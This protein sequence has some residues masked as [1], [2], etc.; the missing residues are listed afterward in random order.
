MVLDT[1]A[2][3]IIIDEEGPGCEWEYYVTSNGEHC[4]KDFTKAIIDT[5][6]TG[7]GVDDRPE[8]E[9]IGHLCDDHIDRAFAGL[10]D[11]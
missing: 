7:I 5:N 11:D 6:Y 8:G 10:N 1:Q 2:R 4:P 3:Y 9:H